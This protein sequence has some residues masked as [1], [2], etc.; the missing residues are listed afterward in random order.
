MS[1]KYGDE[2]SVQVDGKECLL[3]ELEQKGLSPDAGCRSASCGVC[4]CEVI[5]GI[6]AFNEKDEIESDTI[7]HLDPRS[8]PVRLICRAKISNPQIDVILKSYHQ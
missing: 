6:E 3:D 4:A 1:V 7:A 8:N 5:K 2:Q